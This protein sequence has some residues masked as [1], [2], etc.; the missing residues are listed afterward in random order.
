MTTKAF[1]AYPSGHPIIDETVTGLSD[2]YDPLKLNI[3]PWRKMKSVGLKLDDLIRDEI[4]DADFLIADITFPNFNVYYEIGYAAAK[5]LPIIPTINTGVEP[6][7]WNSQPA[8][9]G[10]MAKPRLQVTL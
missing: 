1:F 2:F 8:S 7:C 4:A 10:P 5:G 3:K 9:V 6:T